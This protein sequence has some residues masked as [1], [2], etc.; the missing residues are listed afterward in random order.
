[1]DM[2][3]SNVQVFAL[4]EWFAL[5][6]SFLVSPLYESASI[7]LAAEFDCATDGKAN[8]VTYNF[9]NSSPLLSRLIVLV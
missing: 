6:E 2:E 8:N 3:H 7:I 9:V 4:R 1:M 5:P